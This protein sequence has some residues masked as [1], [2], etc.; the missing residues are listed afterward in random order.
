MQKWSI[1]L[2][3]LIAVSL[4]S[5]GVYAQPRSGMG[6]MGPG[7]MSGDG[8]SM[9]LPL[10]LKGVDLTAAQQTRVHAIMAA[11]RATFRTLFSEFQAAHEAIADKLFAAGQVHVED[12]TGQVQRAAQVREQLMQEGLKVALE[13]RALLTPDQI[14]K[15]AQLKDRVRALRA[16][17][18]SLFAEEP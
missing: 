14:A 9:L 16:E 5:A 12:L 8:L 13:V 4:W 10:V 7:R 18:R 6:G 2:I 17:M 11:H 15:A 3:G 1:A